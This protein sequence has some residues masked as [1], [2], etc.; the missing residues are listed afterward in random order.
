MGQLSFLKYRKCERS[1]GNLAKNSKGK[2]LWTVTMTTLTVG[3]V[4]ILGTALSFVN[5]VEQAEFT[6]L[7]QQARQT[8]EWAI[9][10]EMFREHEKVVKKQFLTN[11]DRSIYSFY[12]SQDDDLRLTIESQALKRLFNENYLIVTESQVGEHLILTLYYNPLH[13]PKASLE[14][15][16]Q[17]H[18]VVRYQKPELVQLYEEEK[19]LEAERQEE[20]KAAQK[21]QTST[22]DDEEVSTEEI[23]EDEEAK[24][25][26]APE[27]ERLQVCLN[28][29]SFEPLYPFESNQIIEETETFI[30]FENRAMELD[31]DTLNVN[32]YRLYLSED[33]V[34]SAYG[35]DKGLF[36]QSTVDET[37]T[38]EKSEE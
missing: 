20:E 25:K 27:Y 9:D 3:Q 13:D 16:V 19:R 5:R 37:N 26:V 8:V 12:H 17:V 28:V 4:A 32:F 31:E 18:Q 14:E 1:D 30:V 21:E 10:E 22:S 34:K 33:S 35:W 7:K 2:L 24:E 36:N 29:P 15:L 23:E 38:T 11:A 6:Y